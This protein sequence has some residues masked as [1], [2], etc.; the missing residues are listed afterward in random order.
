MSEQI[1]AGL[2]GASQHTAA[3]I[4]FIPPD[5]KIPNISGLPL[6]DVDPKILARR[7]R[8]MTWRKRADVICNAITDCLER[9][10]KMTEV[11][12]GEE[13]QERLM[14][15]SML[16]IMRAIGQ[17]LHELEAANPTEPAAVVLF[18]LSLDPMHRRAAREW[19]LKR[20]AGSPTDFFWSKA[21]TRWKSLRGFFLLVSYAWPGMGEAWRNGISEPEYSGIA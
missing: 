8:P 6:A 5:D 1:D 19:A 4:E 12:D 11:L 18:F 2:A 14:E 13:D 21:T 9:L 15:W 7:L 16:Q 3:V 20:K 17:T 10:A